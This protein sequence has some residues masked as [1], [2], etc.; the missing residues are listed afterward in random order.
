M[1]AI[2]LGVL[3]HFYLAHII[4]EFAYQL[5][6]F[7]MSVHAFDFGSWLSRLGNYNCT[8]SIGFFCQA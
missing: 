4:E 2:L 7:L 8:E 1:T 6:F 5:I 3:F